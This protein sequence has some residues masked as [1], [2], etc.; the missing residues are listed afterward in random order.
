[1]GNFEQPVHGLPADTDM[2]ASAIATRVS[3]PTSPLLV[4]VSMRAGSGYLFILAADA[5]A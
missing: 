2:W 4:I 5:D 3:E 1:V